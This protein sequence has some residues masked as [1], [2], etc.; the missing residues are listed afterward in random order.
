LTAGVP[1]VTLVDDKGAAL[2]FNILDNKDHTYRVE[3]S[4][5]TV[6]TVTLTVTYAKQPVPKSP[7]KI[8][9]QSGVKVYG[10]AV[11]KPV[12]PHHT[13]YLT[14]DCKQAGPGQRQAGQ[15]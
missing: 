6:T 5:I 13:T 3:F 15:A 8:P 1:V 2:P 10:P 11:E 12:E 4:V 9:V 14:V 7:F